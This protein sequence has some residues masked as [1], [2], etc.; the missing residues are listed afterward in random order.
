M[1]MTMGPVLGKS[2]SVSSSCW[3]KAMIS[4]SW[5]GHFGFPVWQSRAG[6]SNTYTSNAIKILVKAG[7]WTGFWT[8]SFVFLC[9][10]D[11]SDRIILDWNTSHCTWSET[12]LQSQAYHTTRWP[13]CW[14]FQKPWRE[15]LSILLLALWEKQMFRSTSLEMQVRRNSF[16]TFFR[17]LKCLRVLKGGKEL[18]PSSIEWRETIRVT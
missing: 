9:L 12:D 1:L 5:N 8:R 11:I 3:T 7:L 10:M 15:V 2:E 17:P 18:V 13:C 4:S 6:F 16:W 14:S